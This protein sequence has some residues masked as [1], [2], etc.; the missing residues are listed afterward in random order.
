M[1]QIDNT[2]CLLKGF[3]LLPKVPLLTSRQHPP[4]YFSTEE[5]S[6]RA[7]NVTA[8]FMGLVVLLMTSK[9]IFICEIAE[10]PL[11]TLVI[12]MW[13]SVHT[14]LVT[15]CRG[16]DYAAPFLQSVTDHLCCS[17]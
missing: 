14:L 17:L 16:R 9:V 4:G 10:V 15:A 5:S 6:S 1:L 8:V 7:T 2:G 3:S 12:L 13:S 11:K